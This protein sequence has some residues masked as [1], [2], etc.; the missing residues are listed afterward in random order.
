MIILRRN[1]AENLWQAEFTAEDAADVLE[2]FGVNI[3]PTPFTLATEGENVKRYIQARNP[4]TIVRL[5]E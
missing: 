4:N 3:L 2:A 5:E 1:K